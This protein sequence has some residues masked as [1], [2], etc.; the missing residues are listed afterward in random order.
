MLL[1]YW[2]HSLSSFEQTRVSLKCRLHSLKTR[3]LWIVRTL[4][5]ECVCSG[6]LAKQKSHLSASLRC[7]MNTVYPSFS[8][9]FGFDFCFRRPVCFPFAG[10]CSN[11]ADAKDGDLWRRRAPQ[12]LQGLW[13]H[14]FR[15]CL[16][17]QHLQPTDRQIGS[18]SH[19]M[20]FLGGF[21]KVKLGRH[22]L[23]GEKV[24]IKIINKRELGVSHWTLLPGLSQLRVNNRHLSKIWD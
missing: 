22:I 7:E 8:P 14:R 21:A 15:Y 19:S 11:D 3:C 6:Y 13:D 9:E 5:F 10:R 18:F 4:W 1:S 23:T 17:Q 2:A 24:A 20:W 12:I 16:V